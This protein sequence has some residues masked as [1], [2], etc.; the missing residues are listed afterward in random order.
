MDD[1]NRP[2]SESMTRQTLRNSLVGVA[3]FMLSLVVQFFYRRSFIHVLGDSLMGLNGTLAGVI[4]F[5]N[6]AELG[7]ATAIGFALYRPLVEGDRQ[8][9][10][11]IVSLQGWFYRIICIVIG[12]VSGV[13]LFFF[14]ALLGDLLET[15][16]IPLWYAYSTFLVLLLNSLLGY[17][18]NY[19]QILL[20]S[21]LK[22]YKVTLVLRGTSVLKLSLQI[23]FFYYFR[24]TPRI[25]YITWIV[26]EALGAVGQT[27]WLEMIIRKDYPWLKT[28]KKAGFRLRLKY[29]NIMR[30]TGQLFF[31]KI[32]SF[33][34]LM[35]TPLIIAAV[36]EARDA[37][38]MVSVYQNYY[39]L[40]SA[41]SGIFTA[42]FTAFTPSIGK[43]RASE[44]GNDRIELL[45]RSLLSLRL[46]L[47]F[48]ACFGIFYFSEDLM[49]LW[50][51][52][53]RYF[54]RPETALFCIY[55]FLQ[56]SR[57]ADIFIEA[58]GMFQDIWAPIVEAL[59]LLT[60]SF[61]LGEIWGL[62]GIFMGMIISSVVIVHIWKPIFLYYKG[63]EKSP[64]I[65][66]RSFLL[67]LTVMGGGGI[68]FFEGFQLL[69]LKLPSS[70]WALLLQSF[71]VLTLYA[72]VIFAVSYV[73]LPD[74]RN[75]IRFFREKLNKLRNTIS[76]K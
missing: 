42:L 7:L 71:G 39:L 28:D 21:D 17:I 58:Y 9:V 34:V 37:L 64:L 27:L 38:Y 14:P 24:S 13:L 52:G 41:F 19:R 40:L 25:A 2:L 65:Y 73:L 35:S 11:E 69:T 26:I 63:F 57:N 43:L 33:V 55:C 74:L 10:K 70:L 67:L 59:L 18:F 15:N 12:V 76:P 49:R 62:G 8:A 60:F 56:L 50:V 51:G 44:A 47:S 48:V 66:F 31:H 36:L 45:F 6:I 68:L 20:F 3:F 32:T 23:A 54:S 22:G 75:G 5:L 16:H 1:P 61:Y 46:L 72:G 30:K 29:P 53:N 4:N